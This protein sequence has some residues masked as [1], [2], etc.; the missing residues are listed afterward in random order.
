MLRMFRMLA[1]ALAAAVLASIAIA[2]PAQAKT[3]DVMP[4]QSIQA[5]ID[6]ASP[7]DTIVVHPGTYR[8]NV[9]L[10]KNDVAL[11][12]SGA[13]VDGT[14]LIPPKNPPKGPLGGIGIAVIV[15]DSI[16][17]PVPLGNVG[18]EGAG[19]GVSDRLGGCPGSMR[20][21]YAA[22]VLP[23]PS[24]RSLPSPAST[25][26]NCSPIAPSRAQQAKDRGQQ[27]R[28]EYS[29]NAQHVWTA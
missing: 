23:I 16:P 21:R 14:V 2:V 10:N 9:N 24:A 8:E 12:G 18:G 4:G 1:V 20:A 3:I 13:S 25:P 11:K 26:A 27:E 22:P 5:A 15:R 6:S 19:G 7:G 28:Q 17:R 29:A